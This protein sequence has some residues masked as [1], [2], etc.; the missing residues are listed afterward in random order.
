MLQWQHT[1]VVSL[2]FNCFMCLRYFFFQMFHLDVSK[3]DLVLHMLQWLYTHV[4][5]ISS[6]F[7]RMLHMFYLDV[8]K[9]DQVLHDTGGR[10]RAACR[11]ASAPT[12][13]LPCAAHLTLSSPLAPLP[14][15]LSI[16]PW[17]F[18]LDLSGMSAGEGVACVGCKCGSSIWTDAAFGA[19]WA[20]GG[21]SCVCHGR[22]RGAGACVWTWASILALAL[23]YEFTWFNLHL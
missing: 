16:S 19:G 13:R 22:E 7:R 9:V 23:P 3:F 14:S 8:S 6:V 4:L 15:L 2:C 18:E 11:R 17:Q 1:H 10:R 5:S 12:L 20:R 21:G